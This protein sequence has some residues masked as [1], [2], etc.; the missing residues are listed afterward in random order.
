MKNKTLVILLAS[1]FLSS[2]VLAY[3]VDVDNWDSLNHVILQGNDPVISK[4][5]TQWQWGNINLIN[6]DN[7]KYPKKDWYGIYN[8]QQN[9]ITLK[10]SSSDPARFLQWHDEE[11]GGSGL[12]Y[13]TLSLRKI[14][15][16]NFKNN[17]KAE[18][19]IVAGGAI[20]VHSNNENNKLEINEVQF[21]N[22]T[23]ETSESTV[24]AEGGALRNYV[25]YAQDTF[26]TNS[27]FENNTAKNTSNSSNSMGG[28][29]HIG[30]S[31]HVEN[32]KKNNIYSIADS[33][34]KQ[35]SAANG[36]AVS[37]NT[38][39]DIA[40]TNIVE[41]KNVEFTNNTAGVHGGAIYSNTNFNILADGSGKK[42]IIQGNTLTDSTQEAIYVNSANATLT[43][44][45]YNGGNIEIYDII[46]G[47]S[48]Y[49]VKIT[50]D[51]N[52][53]VSLYHDLTN[54]DVTA[55]NVN[56]DLSNGNAQIYNMQ[57]L[58]SKNTAKWSIDLD[59]SK[60]SADMI[61]TTA[62]STGTIVIDSLNTVGKSFADL[63]KD[64]TSDTF[65][66]QILSTK[67]ALQ[68]AFSDKLTKELA[69]YNDFILDKSGGSRTDATINAVT[70]WND[71]YY[72][73][74]V[75][76]TITYG[77]LGLTTTTTTNDSI[78]IIESHKVVGAT[79]S[80][81]MGDTL[82]VV[83]GANIGDRSFKT[84]D[85]SKTYNVSSDIGTVAEGN[86][87]IQ[88]AI[89]AD[90]NVST[91]NMNSKKGFNLTNET[92]LNLSHLTVGG[93]DGALVNV[94]NENAQIKLNNVNLNSDITGNVDYK[95]NI[96][97]KANITSKIEQADV[98]AEDATLNFVADTFKDSTLSVSESK[99]ELSDGTATNYNIGSLTSDYTTDWSIDVN[100]TERK[101]DTISSSNSTGTVYINKINFIGSSDEDIVIQVLKNSDDNSNLQL[102]LNENTL[103]VVEDASK[104][105]NTVYYS[106][107]YIKQEAGIALDKTDTTNDSIK[108]YKGSI[109]DAL[110]LIN[111]KGASED[112]LYKFDMA[113]THTL[114]ENLQA[115]TA[116]SL[117]IE[118]YQS[119]QNSVIDANNNS[120]FNLANET[121]LNLSNVTLTNASGD[122]IKVSDK[123]ELNLTNVL[124][125]N[126]GGNAI[127]ASGNVNLNVKD[128]DLEMSE[129]I[130]MNG[131]DLTLN[132]QNGTLNLNNSISGQDYNLILSGGDIAFNG[133][134]SGVKD[135]EMSSTTVLGLGL[136][137]QLEVENL[138][139]T[140]SS[141]MINI[142]SSTS[143]T[144]K[145]D[146]DIADNKIS[147]GL[148]KVNGDVSGSYGVIVKALSEQ[149][150]SQMSAFLEALNDDTSTSSAFN[151]LRVEGNPYMW[152][153]VLNAEGETQGSTWYLA[154]DKK[155]PS[156]D[157]DDDT[158]TDHTITPEI[159]AGV[160]LHEAAI[161]QTRSV[162]RNVS[163]KVASARA[164][165]NNCGIVSDNW[166]GSK[167]CN[168][169]VVAQGEDVNIEK[170]VDMD[171]K[172]WGVEAGFDIQSDINNTLGMFVSYRNG[173][174]DL[175]GKTSKFVD[176][177][178]S[179]INID[180]YLAGL[181]YRYD[182]NNTWV[183]AS[184]YGGMQDANIDTDDNV[185]N[186]ETDGIEF[187]AN[188]EAGY[189]F[190]L[191]K[192]TTL[193]PSLAV[194][195]TQ[196]NFD[197]TTDNVKK[198]YN[199]DD[200]KHLEAELALSLE[201]KLENGKVYVKP[202]VIQTLT[203]DDNVSISS[204]KE[205]GTYK[206]GTLG[207]VEIGGNYNFNNSLSG[208]G[209]INYTY[210]SNYNATA[211][212]VGLNYSW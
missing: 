12:G 166:D 13:I 207:R 178:G 182:K 137:G 73:T 206:D 77:K 74:V 176:G 117:T 65:K 1:T 34:F 169:W 191:N 110:V 193:S 127:S 205:I 85:A 162:V 155:E 140:S 204:L 10:G 109:Y 210:G 185:V 150:S 104:I 158:D 39:A 105:D 139:Q 35:N 60:N 40:K 108:I 181:Y 112:R 120:L 46:N 161:E 53:T 23:A 186:I 160:G 106:N 89:D 190:V 142:A 18:D 95:M 128:T 24:R 5:L 164:F 100:A 189:S 57:S 54:A 172:I 7:P 75:A 28:A 208:Y 202:S 133:N 194:K 4:D 59:L 50:G 170:P 125:N 42:T 121:T 101:S 20:N 143:P 199:W 43:L 37:I 192:K 99:I 131:A 17:Q 116:G 82:S 71:V 96:T 129:N 114:G 147:N 67:G 115:T 168:T 21:K 31:K 16:H 118:G 197:E 113:G 14:N 52:S 3:K 141:S 151:V 6:L 76:D 62:D 93:A 72:A 175:S 30:F 195:Y 80:E 157:D 11:N 152:K 61:E 88:G 49:D 29:M 203:K 48:G 211:L 159:I 148:I 196:I 27:L 177:I 9:A 83:A 68:L 84:S 153:T 98:T 138:K 184:V 79:T 122:A 33:K 41:F 102:A 90:G 64:Q 201:R 2:N 180:S 22:N 144:L 36:G 156:S 212:G 134:I 209:W 103:K 163:N 45:S 63:A 51:S 97:G 92:T 119:A 146:V 107:N 38:E 26:I 47:V 132:A 56:I 81:K 8:E 124:F 69:D 19:N 15:L 149:Y 136:R 145:I 86:L 91:V 179:E 25:K 58:N 165:C 200:I 55:E 154:M 111:N 70:G 135:M 87:S 174:Y 44:G 130:E 78:G 66:V 167:L 187:G 173:E 188:A 171:G 94:T 126:N 198:H 123:A 32:D 183:F